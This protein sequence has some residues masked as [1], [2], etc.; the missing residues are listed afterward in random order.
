MSSVIVTEM[1]SVRV[2]EVTGRL[3]GESA[4]EL[5]R[6]MDHAVDQ[7]CCQLVLDLG[8]VDYI[9][10]PGLR[11]IVRV[12]KRVLQDGGQPVGPRDGCHGVGR[13]G[14]HPPDLPDT[15]RCCQ[16]FLDPFLAYSA[17]SG[18]AQTAPSPIQWY[19][20][21]RAWKGVSTMVMEINSSEMRRVQL[22]EI[23]GRVDSSNANELGSAMDR[24][25]DD[26]KNNV[27]LDLGE[28]EYM[29]SAGLREMVRVLKRVKRSGGDLRIANPSD[30]VKEVLELAGLDTIFEIYPTQV[31]AVGSF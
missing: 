30:R 29:S 17:D 27:V 8:S 2:V 25:V 6:E 20:A 11:E 3:D 1:G 7:G 14:Q 22:F 23:M 24:A 13:A 12:Y 5:G 21:R 19:N 15:A 18:Q 4:P 28:V 9:S 26:G 31:E 16:Q 10:S